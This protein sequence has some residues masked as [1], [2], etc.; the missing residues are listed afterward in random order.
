MFDFKK[1]ELSIAEAM[2][3]DQFALKKTLQAIKYKKNLNKPSDAEHN[4]GL[5]SVACRAYH[6]RAGFAIGKKHIQSNRRA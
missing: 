2:I 5:I 6:L 3:A 1:A 4:I